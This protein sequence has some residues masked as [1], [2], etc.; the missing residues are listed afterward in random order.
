M[1]LVT[2]PVLTRATDIIIDPSCIR[3]V[4][5]DMALDSNSGLDVTR[6]LVA[7]QYTQT[8]DFGNF[9]NGF[10]LNF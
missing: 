5:L 4:D 1:V 3:T 9:K 7:A 10:F 6:A 2:P 8:S